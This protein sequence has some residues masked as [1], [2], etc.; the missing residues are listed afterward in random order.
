MKKLKKH[1]VLLV[2]IIVLMIVT[3]IDA[4]NYIKMKNHNKEAYQIEQTRCKTEYAEREDMKQHCESISEYLD[5]KLYNRD[6]ISTFFDL[7]REPPIWYFQVFGIFF[8]IIPAIWEF[9][10]EL[11]TGFIKNILTR[12]EYKSYMLKKLV[13]AYKYAFILPI[14]LIFLFL[15]SY[16]ISGHFNLNNTLKYNPGSLFIEDYFLSNLPVFLLFYI[17]NLFLHSIFWI[18]LSFII[19]KKSNHIITTI[20]LTFLTYLTLEISFQV[21]VGPMPYLIFGVLKDFVSYIMMFNIW[22]YDN[23]YNLPLK[24]SFTLFLI[25]I[26][27]FIIKK[28]YKNKEGVIISNE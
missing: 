4:N 10:K 8:V 17:A 27:L 11:K 25:I 5:N 6:T 2:V 22:H 12:M 26:T 24:L 18:N 13:A 23:V 9:H 3:G 1:G 28:I 14:Y 15:V 21:F 7:I 19:A 16:L 20:V